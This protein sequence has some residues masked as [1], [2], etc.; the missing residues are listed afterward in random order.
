MHS[1]GQPARP[2]R[3]PRA[4]SACPALPCHAPT[5]RPARHCRLP[6]PAPSCRLPA[7]RAPR[8]RLPARLAHP[9]AC[10]A[11]QHLALQLQYNF[12]CIAIQF[13]SLTQ[14]PQSRYKNCIMTHCLPSLQ[15]S[16]LSCNI[17]FLPN[18]LHILT[19]QSAVLQYN[20]QPSSL[21]LCNTKMVL[22]YKFSLQLLSSLLSCNT[23]ARLA[24]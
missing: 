10:C 16:K 17:V 23:I 7:A 9:S 5:A 4:Q 22:Q 3:A 24:I 21:P 18:Q 13:L 1:P 11:P 15:Y 8:A 14:L 20:F 19:I 12:F 6:A 2:V